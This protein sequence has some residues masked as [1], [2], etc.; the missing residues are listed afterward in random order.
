MSTEG[1][2]EKIQELTFGKD[3][4][5]LLDIFISL[6]SE[7]IATIN[8][9]TGISIDKIVEEVQGELTTFSANFVESY[10]HIKDLKEG[11]H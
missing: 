1:L 8:M 6:S 11:M 9:A 5:K 2:R 10:K 3:A 7:V 4:Y